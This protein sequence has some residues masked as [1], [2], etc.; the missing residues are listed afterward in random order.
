MF[1]FF[2]KKQ[3]PLIPWPKDASGADELAVFLT[4]T[5]DKSAEAETIM[6]LLRAY[7]IPCFHYYDSE[8][9]A[10]KVINGFSG[11]GVSIYVPESFL[12][13][14]TDLLQSTPIKGE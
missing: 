1:S 12:Q 8:G 2:S 14:A 9:S 3:E 7:Q 5:A 4:H 11:Y 13:E 6:S 10:G